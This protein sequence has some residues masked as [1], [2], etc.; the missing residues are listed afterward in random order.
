MTAPH[1]YWFHYTRPENAE[2]ICESGQY[3]VGTKANPTALCGLYLTDIPPGARE[4]DIL[5]ILFASQRDE[6]NV[7]GVVVLRRQLLTPLLDDRINTGR[8]R[9]Q[10]Y[11]K[12]LFVAECGTTLDLSL[13]IVGYGRRDVRH[14]LYHG[15]VYA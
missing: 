2:A 7:R 9:G 3:S 14:W 6:I 8:R 12:K 10:G 13:S 4:Q 5:T 11:Q 15:S 1:S